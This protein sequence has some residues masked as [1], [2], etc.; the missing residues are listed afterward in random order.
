M[1]NPTLNAGN[2]AGKRTLPTALTA[3]QWR[4]GQSGNPGG[5]GGA[6][7]ECLRLARDA[8]PRAVH[9][10]IELMD[11][12]DERVAAVAANSILDRAFGKPKEQPKDAPDDSPNLD[13]STLGPGELD[14][15]AR[16]VAKVAAS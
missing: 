1:S 7:A 14:Q 5:K 10:L 2:G 8:S 9:R 16:L 12:E 3:H 11:S 13:L 15:L 4:P 6:Y